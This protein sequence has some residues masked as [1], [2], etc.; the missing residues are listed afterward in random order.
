VG[1]HALDV[2]LADREVGRAA[3]RGAR[4]AARDVQVA[5]VVGESQDDAVAARDLPAGGEVV[6]S[7]ARCWARAALTVFGTLRA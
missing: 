6:T 2:E 1:E 5:D 4:E 7:T 3:D